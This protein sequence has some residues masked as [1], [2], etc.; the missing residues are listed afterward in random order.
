M[1]YILKISKN[2]NQILRE[3]EISLLIL[4]IIVKKFKKKLVN[5]NIKI[6]SS[7]DINLLFIELNINI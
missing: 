3:Y 5:L 1:V 7:Y 4:L 6:V 2:F